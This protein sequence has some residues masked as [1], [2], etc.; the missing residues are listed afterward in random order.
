MEAVRRASSY[1][2]RQRR[3]CLVVCEQRVQRTAGQAAACALLMLVSAPRSWAQT[4]EEPLVQSEEPGTIVTRLHVPAPEHE[5]RAV[6]DDPRAFMQLTPDVYSLD[7]QPRGKCKLLRLD[8][9]GLFEPLQYSTLR[10]PRVGGWHESLL[11]SDSFTRY[12][13]DMQFEPV[14]GGTNIVYRLSVG[15]DLPVPDMVISKNVKRSARLTMQAVRDLFA[16]QD[17]ASTPVESPE[18]D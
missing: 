7:V 1:T 13:A 18:D 15:I 11:E 3:E 8:T 5:V 10:C 12:D 16:R 14:P 2:P 4:P 17:R 6:L 9:R